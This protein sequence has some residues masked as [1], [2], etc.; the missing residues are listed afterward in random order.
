MKAPSSGLNPG[1]PAMCPLLEWIMFNWPKGMKGNS[2]SLSST[3]KCISVSHGSIKNEMFIA[4]SA[5]FKLPLKLGFL[6]TSAGR[7]PYMR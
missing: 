7:A 5:D 1:S 4:M 3:R 6:E 2:A